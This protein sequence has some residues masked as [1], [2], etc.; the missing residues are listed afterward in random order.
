[1][2]LL[3]FLLLQALHQELD[4][5]LFFLEENSGT[6]HIFYLFSERR[7]LL[8]LKFLYFFDNETSQSL[9]QGTTAKTVEWPR[10]LYLSQRYPTAAD[11]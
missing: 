11:C 6:T 7:F 1:M 5:E 4:N 2:K 3:V 10:V 9:E 8:L